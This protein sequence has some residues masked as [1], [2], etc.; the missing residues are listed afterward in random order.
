MLFASSDGL[1]LRM[2][3]GN[4]AGFQEHKESL[5]VNGSLKSNGWNLEPKFNT[6]LCD[7]QMGGSSARSSLSSRHNQENTCI[8]ESVI[9]EETEEEIEIHENSRDKVSTARKSGFI[10]NGNL[11]Q[12]RSKYVRIGMDYHSLFK[13]FLY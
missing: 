11:F 6:Y 7:I 4:F 1:F 12:Q 9:Q 3:D 2:L 5:N 8:R 10:D 13:L